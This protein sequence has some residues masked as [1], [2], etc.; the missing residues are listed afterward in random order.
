MNR[1]DFHKTIVE[2][3]STPKPLEEGLVKLKE[4]YT[5]Y[6]AFYENDA[7]LKFKLSQIRKVIKANQS[8]ELYTKST[9]SEYFNL[10]QEAREAIVQAY[11]AK[12]TEK[13]NAQVQLNEAEIMRTMR[14]LML[15][16]SV[17]DTII[18]VLL[19]TG[20]RAYEVLSLSKFKAV[21]GKKSYLRV[22]G[23][24]KKREDGSFVEKPVIMLRPR[25][26]I[27]MIKQIRSHFKDKSLIVD[28]KVASNVMTSLNAHVVTHFPITATMSNKSSFMRK[29]YAS[30]SYLHFADSKTTNKNTWI[31]EMLGH[32]DKLTSFSYSYVNIV[33]TLL[34][35]APKAPE[36]TA[37]VLT[38]RKAPAS[39]KQALLNYHY[40]PG[41][42]NA[43][44]RK[45]TKMG[46]RIVNS[47]LK[48]LN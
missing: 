40:T 1:N 32:N 9:Y 48:S 42:T 33:P 12:I 10:P 28:G 45:K 17:Y 22:E 24:A 31:S 11:T 46:S 19:A 21:V 4:A 36:V 26:T 16:K 34:E 18:L 37:P 5:Q 8:P 6:R 38:N 25:Q 7:T 15:S 41:M 2:Y 27:T 13:N 43:E 35:K 14:T 23:L 30:L 29:I 39:E 3:F 20:C 47:Y 44:L